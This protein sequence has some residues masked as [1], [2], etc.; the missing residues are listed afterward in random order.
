[1]KTLADILTS[2][3]E[4]C[5]E[6]NKS[7]RK[8]YDLLSSNGDSDMPVDEVDFFIKS[9]TG[10]FSAWINEDLR[11][12]IELSCN[13][14][15]VFRTGL[16][17]ALSGLQSFDNQTIYRM[18]LPGGDVFTTLN[19]FKKRIGQSFETPY[20]LSTSKDNFQNTDII[21]IIK[22]LATDSKGKD[23][24]NLSTSLAEKE[25]LFQTESCFKILG[26]D[27]WKEEDDYKG[28]LHLEEMPQGTICNVDVTGFYIM[29]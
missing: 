28:Y 4:E 15:K 21:W 9:Y 5:C 14:K 13:C 19:W 29:K 8:F 23:I 11:N 7:L 26:V 6:N 20:F 12:G 10:E 17:I 18:D 22:T 1:M 2:L 3:F 16:N 24:S 25:I 27:I